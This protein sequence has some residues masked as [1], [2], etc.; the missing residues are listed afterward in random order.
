M[1]SLMFYTEDVYLRHLFFSNRVEKINTDAIPEN[2]TFHNVLCI[3]IVLER[4]ARY[5]ACAEPEVSILGGEDLFINAGSFLNLTCLARNLPGV[6]G[7][8]HWFL[9]TEVGWVRSTGW[10]G[11]LKIWISKSFAVVGC[12]ILNDW[13]EVFYTIYAEDHILWAAGRSDF[14]CGL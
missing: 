10:S 13:D 9:Q 11:F 5:T 6:P 12:G 14:S 8:V 3:M 7:D 1:I 2:Q 4:D